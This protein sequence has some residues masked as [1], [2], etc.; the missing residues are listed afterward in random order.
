MVTSPLAARRVVAGL[1]A[2]I[3]SLRTTSPGA[4]PT[5]SESK[6][7]FPS[8]VVGTLQTCICLL[9]LAST[10]CSG[11]AEDRQASLPRVGS[12]AQPLVDTDS[13]GMDDAWETSH[14]GNLSQTASGDYDSDEM[15]N[16]EEYLYGFNP[17]TKDAL[18]D[19][20]GDR[21][22]NI[23]ELRRSSDPNSASSIPTPN[24]T[25]N[26][27]GGGTHTTIS[28]AV[29]AATTANGAYQI[30]GIAPGVY[31]GA[32]NVDNLTLASTKPKLLVIGLEGAAK[33][34]IEGTN[35]NYGWTV[36]N[37]AVIA[38]LTF[39]KTWLAL[40]VN[41]ASKDVRF[42][43]LV[44][45]D[46]AH[47]SWSAGVHVA[48]AATVRIIGST[49]IDNAGM[50]SAKQIYF[51]AGAGTLINTAV[52]SQGTGTMLA[53]HSS[54]TMT[55]NYSFVKGQTLTG[56]GNLA[57]STDPK[58]RPGAHISWDSPLRAAGGTVVQ[59]LLDLDG[60]LRPST[61]PDIGADQFIDSDSD[62]LADSWEQ[63]QTGGL[64][65]LTGRTQDADTDGLTNDE[66]YVA[67]TKPNVSDTDGD[68]AS[69]GDEVNV[70]STN[71]LKT[72]TDGD[73]MPDGWEVTYGL[74]PL[75]ANGFEDADGDR[76]PNVFEYVNSTNPADRTSTP[77]PNYVVNGAGGG[78]H[79]SISA[80]V[81]AANV[82]NGAYQI[83]GIAQGTYTGTANVASVDI[84][85]GKPKLLIIGLDGAAKTIVDGGGPGWGWE[86]YS[87]VVI[88]SLTFRNSWLPLQINSAASEVRLVDL[89]VKDNSNGSYAAGVHA[90]SV[91][92][93]YI[94]GSM[95]LN[96]VGAGAA[97]QIYVHGGAATVVN[98]LVWGKTTGTMLGKN[99]NPVL[100]TLTTNYCLVKGQT[101]TGT[102][103]LAGTVDPK[104]RSDGHLRS[105]SPLRGAGGTVAQSRIDIDGELRPSSAPDIGTDQYFDADADSL[106]DFWEVARVGNTT[107]LTGSADNDSDGLNNVGEYDWETDHLNPDTDGDLVKDGVEVTYGRNPLVVDADEL[108]SDVN[109]DG[110]ID[111]IG[112]Q[113]GYAMTSTDSDGD[114]VSNADEALMCTNPLRADTDGDGVAD[115]ADAFP[116]DPLMSVMPSNSQDVTP[117][118]ITL[119]APWY[120]VEQ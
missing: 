92:K 90:F 74:S 109:G 49:F 48:S 17:T 24:Y 110:L 98:T 70:H 22:P 73:D 51:G 107:A 99:A 9:V 76:Y 66:E 30:I 36:S 111:S 54:A 80:A 62:D 37:T 77:T 28:A 5:T 21:Y 27:A 91:G 39:Q 116:H 103:N 67:G 56:T 41:A 35:A 119:T 71:P 117:P 34:I 57:G 89:V 59:S 81:N 114:G 10:S 8:V 75:V 84:T 105:D 19:A 11:D 104:L 83:I 63:I 85:W 78:T 2:S 101:L 46:N 20:D 86:I 23:F 93:L 4:T 18:D 88:S 42:V 100:A 64:T 118:Q 12:V 1:R 60:E 38:S 72:D 16:L 95:F 33:T 14:F 102:G 115:N 94:V 40:Y 55:T 113:L 29:S 106:P 87:P 13:D 7:A 47:A 44:V 32:S 6:R 65:T 68:G 3:E 52:W 15:T 96:N 61:T 108:A 31:T 25:V 112:Y 45:R 82:V 58:L 53:K 97:Q 120:A 43:D 79:T 26:G 50:T 69:D